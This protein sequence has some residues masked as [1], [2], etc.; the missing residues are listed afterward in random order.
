MSVSLSTNVKDSFFLYSTI[1]REVKSIIASLKT[2]KTQKF[3]DVDTKFLKYINN[4]S[5]IFAIL[6]NIFNICFSTGVFPNN[7]KIGEII[8]IHKKDDPC[9]ATNYRPISILSQFDKTLEI[10][11][12]S[13]SFGL[14]L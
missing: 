3:Y 2:H 10:K 8:L 5:T 11:P 7:L 14:S 6:S 9:E 1:A 12:S 13:S 4:K